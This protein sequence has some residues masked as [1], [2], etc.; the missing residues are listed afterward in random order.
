M[1]IT[2]EFNKSDTVLITAYSFLLDAYILTI[3]GTEKDQVTRDE[4]ASSFKEQ[5]INRF[6]CI[7][8][9]IVSYMQ[10]NDIN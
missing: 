3:T 2:R 8:R 9:M 7:D 10:Y 6:S 4:K 1:E 5:V